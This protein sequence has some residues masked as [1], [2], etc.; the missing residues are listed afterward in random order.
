MTFTQQLSLVLPL[1]IFNENIIKFHEA[2]SA[3]AILEAINMTNDPEFKIK[4]FGQGN[5]YYFNFKELF[6]VYL[7]EN[8]FAENDNPLLYTQVISDSDVFFNLM[9]INIKTYDSSDVEIDNQNFDYIILK[10]V[11]QINSPVFNY[12]QFL[13][14]KADELK[15]IYMDSFEGYPID[16]SFLQMTT[17]LVVQKVTID[18]PGEI[19][20]VTALNATST[21]VSRIPIIDLDGNPL[22]YG[23]NPIVLKDKV[24]TTMAVYQTAETKS[25][26]AYITHHVECS[27]TYLKWFNNSGGWDYW[28][29]SDKHKI[30]EEDKLIGMFNGI[31]DNIEETISMSIGAGKEVKEAKELQ[32]VFLSPEQFAKLK[33]ITHSPKVY[34]WTG[35]KFVEVFVKGKIEYISSNNTGNVY[36]TMAMPRIITETAW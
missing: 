5:Q 25:F 10:S 33:G 19:Q 9:R 26:K 32:A 20:V 6:K 29:F 35:I 2:G 3:Y 12:D 28:L 13:H 23:L 18:T 22:V 24:V 4:P 17:E 7:N 14:V 16:V 1:N 34:M 11:V 27:G 8:L 36:L 15:T 31:P 21:H 30:K